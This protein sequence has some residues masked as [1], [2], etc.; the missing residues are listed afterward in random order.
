VA[1]IAA[2]LV[3]CT[4]AITAAQSASLQLT[5][6]SA[7][8]HHVPGEASVLVGAELRRP[9][10][11]GAVLISFSVAGEGEPRRT[12]QIDGSS[13]IARG[14]ARLTLPPGRHQLT[15]AARDIAT[16]ARTTTTHDTDVPDLATAPLTAGG[17]LLAS[18][19]PG[20][21]T[22]ADADEDRALPIVLQPPT[23]RREFSRDEKVEV[24][25]ELYQHR[26]DVVQ[27]M[28]V[29]TR[30]RRPGGGVVWET[31][32]LGESETL[33]GG[34]FGYTHSTLL[35]IADLAPGRYLVE[36]AATVSSD[37]PLAISRTEALTIV[38]P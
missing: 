37:V 1:E 31:T 19:M 15:I 27:V 13:D 5:V 4:P 29:T 14:L 32:D 28:H 10:A 12:L 38:A 30:L 7:A 24:Q 18:S 35:P 16:G 21:V 3:L 36:V 20:G 11:D 6:F 17:L 8:F 22:H 9:A 25:V 23:G 34:R 33:P 2:A 26:S